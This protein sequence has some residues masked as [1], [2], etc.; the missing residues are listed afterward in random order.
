VDAAFLVAYAGLLVAAY[1]RARSTAW[2]V[3]TLAGTSA[4]AGAGMAFALDRGVLW[5]RLSLQWILLG[6]LAIVAALAW[7]PW[8]GFSATVA[9]TRLGAEAGAPVS[10]QALVLWLPVLLV[11]IAFVVMTT[12]WTVEPAFLRPVSFLIGNGDAEDN[13]KWL[14]FA[15]QYASG[16]PISQW[17]PMGGPLAL[18]MTGVG[19]VMGV[20]SQVFLGGYNEVAVAAN[21]VIFAQFLMVGLVLLALAPFV[22]GRIRGSRIPAPIVWV[23]MIALG[24][25]TMVLIGFG[26]LTLQFSILVAAL[27]SVTF[28]SGMPM[29]R[30]RLLTSLAVAAATLV[31]LPL[32]GIAVVIIVG[33]LAVLLGR[34]L[35]R[36]WDV[37]ALA[38]VVIVAVGLWEPIRSSLV[39]SLDL[40]AAGPLGGAV[41]GISAL[42]STGLEGSP[43][44]SAEGG[45]EQ[46]GPILAVMAIVA[47]LAAAVYLNPVAGPLRTSL[48]RRFIPLG[49]LVASALGI[50]VLDYWATG[51][52]AHYGSLKFAYFTAIVAFASCLPLALLLLDPSPGDGMRPIQ[53]I[54]MA[55]VL[56]LLTLDSLLPR[57][58]ALARPQEWSPPIPFENTSGSYWYPADVNGTGEQPISG[59]PVACVYLPEGSAYPTAIVPSGLSDA[60]RVYNCTRQL[61]GL[62]AADNAGQPLVDWIRREWYTN[63]PAWTDVY[64][65]LAAMPPEVL[66]KPVILLDDGSNV[67]GLESVASLLQRFPK[68]APA[69]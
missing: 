26:H 23:T 32:N 12:W 54:G 69:Q 48:L 39:Y 52:P 18:L 36:T 16:E 61:A 41:R 17:V 50:Y 55:A 38:L 42:V 1:V 11:L 57:A 35:R 7:V 4:I 60:Q 68:P 64:D 59:N 10:R 45:T 8:F 31:W 67:I 65:S 30:A 9:G 62:A 40:Y 20:V 28:L 53:W 19:T 56:A 46:V 6:V 43:V 33:W 44:F 34:G 49:L 63:T 47:V 5:D 51:G 21:S 27:C 15:A 24:S 29:R 66:A 14:D 3:V 2:L 22:E 25:G 37:P 58:V 13:A